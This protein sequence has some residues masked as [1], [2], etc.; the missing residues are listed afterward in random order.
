MDLHRKFQPSGKSS[1]VRGKLTVVASRSHLPKLIKVKISL[2]Y[3]CEKL[4]GE[5]HCLEGTAN[6]PAPNISHYMDS[7]VCYCK[8]LID[9]R[10]HA[11][12]LML[13]YNIGL[14]RVHTIIVTIVH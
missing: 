6:G 10:C 3:N 4:T 9:C 13:L 11:F 12:W 7:T 14:Y 8:H 5:Y 2:V 1:F